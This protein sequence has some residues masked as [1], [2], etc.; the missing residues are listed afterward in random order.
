MGSGMCSA[1]GGVG[2]EY[3]GPHLSPLSPPPSPL[4]PPPSPL[5]APNQSARGCAACRPLQAR[6]RAGCSRRQFCNGQAGRTLRGPRDH[7]WRKECWCAASQGGMQQNCG[8]VLRGFIVKQA[9]RR[10]GARSSGP[11]SKRGAAQGRSRSRANGQSPEGILKKWQA[12]RVPLLCKQEHHPRSR[13]A[14]DPGGEAPPVAVPG[15]AEQDSRGGARVRAGPRSVQAALEQ[16][17]VRPLLPDGAGVQFHS[18]RV[19]RGQARGQLV[20][21]VAVQLWQSRSGGRGRG[22]GQRFQWAGACVGGGG[23]DPGDETLTWAHLMSA[24]CCRVC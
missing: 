20:A 23:G 24:A 8:K 15:L 1:A 21:H 4:P 19:G 18:L 14:R 6:F 16:Q 13:I 12:T 3:P 11:L 17:G 2:Q 9:S 7:E 10:D 22:A 5:P